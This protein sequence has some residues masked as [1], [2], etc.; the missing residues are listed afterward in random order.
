MM[1]LCIGFDLI[2]RAALA[3]LG[4]KRLFGKHRVR[5]MP[6]GRGMD[7]TDILQTVE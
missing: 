6:C 3:V 4:G 5:V 7:W 1:G 2:N